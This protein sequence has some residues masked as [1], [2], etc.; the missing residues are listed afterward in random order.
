MI[1]SFSTKRRYKILLKKYYFLFEGIVTENKNERQ[2]PFHGLSLEEDLD[3]FSDN[4]SKKDESFEF[5]SFDEK[6]KLVS[7]SDESILNFSYDKNYLCEK[8]INSIYDKNECNTF[9]RKRMACNFH[10]YFKKKK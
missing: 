2:N 5:Y 3:E 8:E 10:K 1:N 4:K 7:E 6:I 9:F